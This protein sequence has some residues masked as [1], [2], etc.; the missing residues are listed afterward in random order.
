MTFVLQ[1]LSQEHIHI[2][3]PPRMESWNCLW[4]CVGLALGW[5]FFI[6]KS[7]KWDGE[8]DLPMVVCWTCFGWGTFIFNSFKWDGGLDLSLVVC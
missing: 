8:L 3:L 4:L 6:F 5:A 7:F 2:P 1:V